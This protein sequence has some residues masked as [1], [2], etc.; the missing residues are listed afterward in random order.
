MPPK[1]RSK[2]YQRTFV[3]CWTCRRRKIKCDATRPH[4]LRCAKSKLECEGY[5]VKLNWSNPLVVKNGE[6]TQENDEDSQDQDDS[7]ST[8]QRSNIALCKWSLY[9]YY[10]DIDLDIEKI[11]EFSKSKIGPFT[12]FR[13]KESN[14]ISSS[15]P[16]PSPSLS[17]LPNRP[18][19][20]SNVPSTSNAT[21]PLQSRGLKRTITG[22][23]IT[24]NISDYGSSITRSSTPTSPLNIQNIHHNLI[25]FAKISIL[26]K[27]LPSSTSLIFP[28]PNQ[29][30]LQHPVPIQTN[31][32]QFFKFNEDIITISKYFTHSVKHFMTLITKLFHTHSLDFIKYIKL[33]IKS[34]LGGY[35]LNN[36]DQDLHLLLNV[37]IISLLNQLQIQNKTLLN[38]IIELYNIAKSLT[39]KTTTSNTS[40][41]TTTLIIILEIMITTT[42][43]T[44]DSNLF[45]YDED[46]LT[47]SPL[48]KI[49]KFMC[50]SNMLI[51][52]EYFEID[53]KYSKFYEDLNQSY[54][55]LKNINNKPKDLKNGYGVILI[56]PKETPRDQIIR[57]PR[58]RDEHEDEQM[59]SDQ[60]EDHADD[61]DNDIPPSFVVNFAHAED[62]TS[63]DEI[64]DT[65]IL[66]TL[67]HLGDSI[68]KENSFG[69][70]N[71]LCYIY[72]EL[73][74]LV[75]HKRIFKKIG[76]S[77]RNFPKICADFEDILNKV[78]DLITSEQ[79][80]AFY[81][82]LIL[83]YYKL[84]GNYP[85]HL[86]KFH[87]NALKNYKGGL[88]LI[89]FTKSILD[90]NNNNDNDNEFEF[91]LNNNDDTVWGNNWEGK[92]LIYEMKKLG[93]NDDWDNYKK[94]K[95]IN[96]IFVL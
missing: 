76:T 77:S 24:T 91:E 20:L 47:N 7:S 49:Y 62:E 93:I 69:I 48:L 21:T 67:D 37:T 61:D 41:D 6:M 55:L 63:D 1:K 83:L 22:T 31:L 92:Q 85:S 9:K 87:Y 13:Y 53:S 23:S 74:K 27:N 11:D 40:N 60:N 26:V 44:Y 19:L 72:E 10:E 66:F 89:W 54:N 79:D 71:C 65:T 81:N 73:M 78:N 57:V 32:D 56:N 5:D 80:H 43:G 12:V 36:N 35:I 45:K 16:T 64:E 59:G 88:G 52:S 3:G 70:S 33:L 94:F 18:L 58:Y 39:F 95:N 75:N 46:S 29:Q 4:C 25:K 86:L 51:N 38:E 84:V 42:L 15:S 17:L 68:L 82:C 96:G 30:S 28:L 2:V 34:S 8:F 50:I 14:D 90:N